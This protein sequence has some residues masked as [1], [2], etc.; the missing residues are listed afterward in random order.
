MHF[1][2]RC[3]GYNESG[4]DLT[5]RGADWSGTGQ[6][7]ADAESPTGDG[8][9]SRNANTLST[10][11]TSYPL[12]VLNPGSGALFAAFTVDPEYNTRAKPG[13]Y[14]TTKPGS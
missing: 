11:P 7:G 5:A 13:I 3:T 14:T 1:V 8:G 9:R 2:P 4:A 6:F 10:V 12:L